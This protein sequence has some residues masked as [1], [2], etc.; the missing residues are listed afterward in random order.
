MKGILSLSGDQEGEKPCAE[1]AVSCIAPE[2]SVMLWQEKGA[3]GWKRLRLSSFVPLSSSWQLQYSRR[4]SWAV[5]A[6]RREVTKPLIRSEL[7][8]VRAVGVY[9]RILPPLLKAIL[10]PRGFYQIHVICDCEERLTASIAVHDPKSPA[11]KTVGEESHLPPIWTSRYEKV[12]GGIR[13]QLNFTAPIAV[14]H[15]NIL[16]PRNIPRELF[17]FHPDSIPGY[18]PSRHRWVVSYCFY[19]RSLPKLCTP[20]GCKRWKQSYLQMTPRRETLFDWAIYQSEHTACV[21]ANS[22][23]R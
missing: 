22:T 13:G 1:L 2:T 15:S 18:K 11:A 6:P 23:H 20:Y 21:V 10:S 3:W 19:R 14:H 5:R 8:L 9:N 12:S 17:L 16:I 7:C 4:Y